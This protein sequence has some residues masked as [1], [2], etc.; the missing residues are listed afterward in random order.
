MGGMMGNAGTAGPWIILWIVLGVLL[1]VT[2]GVI[3]VR[4]LS[5]RRAEL[6]PVRADEP[7]G[8]Q[9]ARATLRMR[10][11]SGEITREDYLQGKVELED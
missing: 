4:V 11:A 9:E 7:P 5:S 1:L 8:L 3:S 6:P 10:Y 2:V